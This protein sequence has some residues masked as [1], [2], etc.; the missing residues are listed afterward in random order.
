MKA[1]RAFRPGEDRL[2][3][4][5]ARS[6][7]AP[8]GVGRCS[9]SAPL[10]GG[11]PLVVDAVLELLRSR[12][13]FDER[14]TRAMART[15]L[16]SIIQ[17]DFEASC[18]VTIEGKHNLTGINYIHFSAM[19]HW[20]AGVREISFAECM[21]KLLNYRDNLD[22]KLR[23][24]FHWLGLE[25]HGGH[26]DCGGSRAGAESRKLM[27]MKD[28]TRFCEQMGLFIP[29]KFAHGD[30][31]LLFSKNGT[32]FHKYGADGYKLCTKERLMDAGGFMRS[33]RKVA[34]RMKVS[35][36]AFGRFLILRAE[37]SGMTVK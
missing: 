4:L 27:S 36:K 15:Y 6:A 23:V 10:D 3:S 26:E 19:L 2:C 5:M 1:L 7:S 32:V 28:F 13:F 25:N 17:G 21:S 22:A 11:D 29:G 18:V 30:V 33:L 16:E 20:I 14:V 37:I 31:H 24:L 34:E 9:R 35:W 8:P 12:K